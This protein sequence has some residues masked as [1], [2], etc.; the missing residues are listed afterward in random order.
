VKILAAYP[1]QSQRAYV[2]ERV[3]EVVLLDLQLGLSEIE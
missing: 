2:V 1:G 3:S